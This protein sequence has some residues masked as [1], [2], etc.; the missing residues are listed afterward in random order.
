ML[1]KLS[2]SKTFLITCFAIGAAALL[3]DPPCS[4]TTL[5]AYFGSFKVHKQQIKH[6]LY[7][8]NLNSS[9]FTSASLCASVN[10]LI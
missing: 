3:P 10:F 1:L 6:D 7:L 8:Y 9:C 5:I 2:R 4:T